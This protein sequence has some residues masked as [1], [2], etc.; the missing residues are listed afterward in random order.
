MPS[1]SNAKNQ[2]QGF[3]H[4]TEAFCQPSYIPSPTT[5]FFLYIRY[6]IYYLYLLQ[7]LELNPNYFLK[8]SFALFSAGDL[9]PGLVHAR[10][11]L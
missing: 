8:L 5:F 7:C 11:A 1:L 2:A 10:Q 4:T 9:T 3:A 6:G